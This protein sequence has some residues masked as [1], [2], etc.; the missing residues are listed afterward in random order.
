M[1]EVVP[2]SRGA[3]LVH[4]DWRS[5][6][7]ALNSDCQKNSRIRSHFTIESA[8]TNLAPAVPI[9][10][11][12]ITEFTEEKSITTPLFVFV[13]IVLIVVILCVA[14]YFSEFLGTTYQQLRSRVSASFS[15]RGTLVPREDSLSSTVCDFSKYRARDSVETTFEGVHIVDQ[16]A[17]LRV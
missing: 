17:A 16:D 13:P 14:I 10:E 1:F 15:K 7:T 8:A 9:A 11:M 12:Q 6:A 2:L 5:S 4:N 3:C